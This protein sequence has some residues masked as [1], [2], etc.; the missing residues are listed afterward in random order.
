MPSANSLLKPI[1]FVNFGEHLVVLLC[2]FVSISLLSSLLLIAHFWPNKLQVNGL[3]PAMR[4]YMCTH[5]ACS[6]IAI[7][8][9]LYTLIWAVL[10]FVEHP[11]APASPYS[12]QVLFWTGIFEG[13]YYAVAPI[14][15]TFLAIERCLTL[16]FGGVNSNFSCINK[17]LCAVGGLVILVAWCASTVTYLTELPLQLDKVSK[18][19]VVSCLAIK[20]LSLAQTCIKNTFGLLNICFCLIFLR[21]LRSFSAAKNMKDRVIKFTIFAEIAFNVLPGLVILI[22][23]SATSISLASYAGEIGITFCNID[24]FVCSIIYWRLLMKPN[25]ASANAISTHPPKTTAIWAVRVNSN[26]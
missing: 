18:C 15:V 20:T 16:Q 4:L 6:A 7:P 17:L 9:Q 11:E 26:R 21:M 1:D 14:T 8:Y 25:A 19:S 22:F 24:A 2:K 3:S 13:N 23:N 10:Q 12:P 5:C